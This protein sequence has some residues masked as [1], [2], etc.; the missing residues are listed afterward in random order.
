LD[1]IDEIVSDIIACRG[2]GHRG[3]GGAVNMTASDTPNS[4]TE[5]KRAE[6]L[7]VARTV[8]HALAVQDADRV[9]TI[10]DIRGRLIARHDLRPE[11]DARETT[12]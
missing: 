3:H 2:I 4:A 1:G 8:Y 5:Q 10:C 11:Q 12:S 9:I 7:D 6:R